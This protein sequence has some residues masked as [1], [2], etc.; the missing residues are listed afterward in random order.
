LASIRFS[1]SGP[2]SSST[3]S[4][5]NP[6]WISARAACS[7][8]FGSS[9]TP[10]SQFELWS[11]LSAAGGNK[12]SLSSDITTLLICRAD[13][14]NGQHPRMTSM[15]LLFSAHSGPS[16]AAY[17]SESLL[18]PWPRCPECPE[19]IANDYRQCCDNHCSELQCRQMQTERLPTSPCAHSKGRTYV[20]DQD[21]PR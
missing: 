20:N 10:T 16:T 1:A 8:I 19:T 2:L 4:C 12:V 11:R 7:A 15:Y 6:A 9:I 18:G 21:S 5:A 3:S 17:A 13:A 14:P